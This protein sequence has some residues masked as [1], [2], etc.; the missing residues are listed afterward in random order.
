[1]RRFIRF[2]RTAL[3]LSLALLSFAAL[4]QETPVGLWKTVD[5]KTG[6]PNSLV[7][8]VESQGVLSGRI[9]KLLRKPGED[10][11][12]L[13][14]DCGGDLRGAPLRG[15]P[16]IAGMKKEDE[17][18]VWSGGTLLDPKTGKTYKST[19]ELIDGGKKLYVRGY[20]GIPLF[21]HSQVW[22]RPQ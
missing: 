7:R 21:G 18:P 19:M 17:K 12:P 10:Q 16:I 5:D 11:N 9:E 3:K 20:I 6:Q 15:M 13:C 4:A 14:N 1:M 22:E 2:A 8:I